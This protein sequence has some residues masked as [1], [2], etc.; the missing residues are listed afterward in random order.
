MPSFLFCVIC[1]PEG[2]LDEFSPDRHSLGI[3]VELAVAGVFG[4]IEAAHSAF[5]EADDVR[6]VMRGAFFDDFVIFDEQFA[7]LFRASRHIK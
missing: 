3:G 5:G 1:E 4:V 6:T 7:L 2:V